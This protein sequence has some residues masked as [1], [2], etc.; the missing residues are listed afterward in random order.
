[1][2]P[3]VYKTTD[4][5]ETWVSI[6][7][8]LPNESVNV[9]QED[10]KNPDLLFVG[11]DK[12]VYVTIDGGE[13]WTRLKNNMPTQPVHDLVIHPRENDLVVGTYGRGFF[14]TDISP[15]QEL[16]LEVLDQE[17]HFFNIEP[18]VQW[19]IPRE[20]VV[21]SQNYSGENESYGLIINYYLKNSVNS[22]VIVR[23][24]KGERM[25]NELRGSGSA[26]LNSVEWR[27]DARREMTEEEKARWKLIY[28]DYLEQPYTKFQEV[29]YHDFEFDPPNYQN[30]PFDPESP[31]H[32]GIQQ[33]PGDY[34]VKLSVNSL[35]W[36][37]KAVILKDDWYI[38]YY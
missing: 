5:G 37:R 1:Y 34:T 18:K 36:T 33:P 11:N 35:E 23:V 16:T 21:S 28:A 15:L 20:N 9:I 22:D 24:Y 14:I 7:A 27:M 6:A 8:N 26:G 31:E 29:S 13:N 17:V 12:A 3:I 19:V 32:I 4:Y 38:K 30:V 25:I 2:R 10:H